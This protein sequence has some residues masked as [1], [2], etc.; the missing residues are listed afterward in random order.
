MRPPCFA[1]WVAARPLFCASHQPVPNF[2]A[3]PDANQPPSLV[4]VSSTLAPT[5]LGVSFG[6]F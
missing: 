2:R 4:W 3:L 6:A 1:R 5:V